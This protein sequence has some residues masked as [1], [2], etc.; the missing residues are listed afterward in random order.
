MLFPA[1]TKAS[2]TAK[3]IASKAAIP[4][5]KIESGTGSVNAYPKYN[6]ETAWCYDCSAADWNRLK[7]NGPTCVGG[8]DGNCC[9]LNQYTPVDFDAG[10]GGGFNVCKDK[11]TS[12]DAP[13]LT[14]TP[15][16]TPGGGGDDGNGGNDGGNNGG[17]DGGNNGGN[18]NSVA[19]GDDILVWIG[20]G[21]GVVVVAAVGGSL[22]QKRMSSEASE[23]LPPGWQ[24]VID[25]KSGDT[26]YHEI[27]TGKTQWN[28]PGAVQ[29]PVAS[30][31]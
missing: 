2:T 4:T 17:N 31:V 16:G 10:T 29:N 3:V 12:G 9:D 13:W 25:E 15:P 20:I 7:I 21:L 27:A 11:G 18:S 19:G 22:L 23:H 14:P 8:I 1:R 24:A 28:R 5:Y 30:R 6:S 26:Y